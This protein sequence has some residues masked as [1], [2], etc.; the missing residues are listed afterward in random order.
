MTY[1]PKLAG[2][3]ALLI[4]GLGGCSPSAEAPKHDATYT[5]TRTQPSDDETPAANA[6]E[7]PVA[8]PA[9]AAESNATAIVVP[10]RAPP[11]AP[12]EQLMDDASATG[13]TARTSRGAPAAEPSSS[14]EPV[15][16]K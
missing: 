7:L 3:V 15:E 16:Q 13:M 11:P 6:T 1:K 2:A 12:D 9:P 5:D 10:E 4:A 14:D 8:A